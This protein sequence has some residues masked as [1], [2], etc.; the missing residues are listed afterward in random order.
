M[1]EAFVY[2]TDPLYEKLRSAG[3]RIVIGKG[4][5]RHPMMAHLTHEEEDILWA[6]KKS[7]GVQCRVDL[8]AM[9]LMLGPIE[10]AEREFQ[11]AVAQAN[12]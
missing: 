12:A 9:R 1:G 7:D 2:E 5:G 4:M 10:Y 6:E 11:R 3:W 8:A